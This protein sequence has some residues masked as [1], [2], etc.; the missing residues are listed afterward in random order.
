MTP[1]FATSRS[2]CCRLRDSKSLGQGVDV[3]TRC[4]GFAEF[5]D[6]VIAQLGFWVLS[7]LTRIVSTL[8]NAVSHI[9]RVCSESQMK[10]VAAFRIVANVHDTQAFW[11]VTKSQF[12]SATMCYFGFKLM[13]HHTVTSIG[14]T[15]PWPTFSFRT[16]FDLGPKTLSVRSKTVSLFGHMLNLT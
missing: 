2:P 7:T 16:A 5:T 11:N 4:I 14:P 6:N 10:R 15:Q 9:V 8:L 3:V 1:R 13:H 12:I